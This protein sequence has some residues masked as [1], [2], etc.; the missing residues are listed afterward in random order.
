MKWRC[1]AALL[2]LVIAPGFASAAGSDT[3]VADRTKLG[4]FVPSSEPFPAP[5]VTLTDT[6]GSE[7][8]LSDFRGK[9]V[10]LNLW[11]TWC[12]P[13]LREMPSL[14]RLQTRFG[15]RI[16]VL[17]VSEDRGG[18]KIVTPFIAKLG[19]ESVKIYL[20]PKSTVERAFKVQGLP[21]SF[22]IDRQSRI[23]GRV[24]GAAEWDAPKLLGVLKSFLGDD[25]IIKASLHKARP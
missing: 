4:E 17:A 9:L 3:D 24:E 22:L 8:G 10:V 7:V 6:A 18:A 25:E 1:A 23:L 13:C 15:D 12:E 19:L 2:I 21:T 20:D 5:S 11:A 14:E 16:A